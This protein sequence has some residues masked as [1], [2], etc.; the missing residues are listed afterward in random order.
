M[1]VCNRRQVDQ[2]HGRQGMGPRRRRPP[3]G[4]LRDD[5]SL[6]AVV[7]GTEGGLSVSHFC[8]PD[9]VQRPTIL[10]G[11]MSCRA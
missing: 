11:S 5:E 8:V 1:V 10:I 4:G 7:Q 9:D 6:L 3:E 2:E